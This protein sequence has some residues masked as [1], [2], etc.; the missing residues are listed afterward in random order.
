[1]N[2]HKRSFGLDVAR[3]LAISFVLI[4]HF[5]KKVEHFGFWGVELFF[6]LSG[7]LIGQILW[8]NFSISSNWG[9]QEILNFWS[10]RWWRTLPNYLLFCLVMLVFHFYMG[11]KLPGP[12]QFTKVLFFSQSLLRRYEQFFGV[13]WSLCIEE[14]FYLLFPA[15]L[16]LFGQLKLKRK[17]T[18]IITLATFF[19]G[20]IFIR[21]VLI[22]HHVGHQLRGITFA[23]LDAI[24][25]GVA[26]A[27]M[28]STVF[29]NY[30]TKLIAFILGFLLL[31]TAYIKVYFTG[32]SYEMAKESQ[33]L[34]IIIPLGFSLLLPLVNILP[35]PSGVFSFIRIMTERMSS[36]AYSIY[37]SHIPVLFL[38][39]Y[40]LDDIRTNVIGNLISKIIGLAITL[41]VSGL[42]YKYFELPFT[43]KRPAELRV[44][45]KPSHVN[46]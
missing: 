5:A 17:A 29:G 6:G 32:I 22:S 34:L 30:K 46:K 19:I 11:D 16:F 35:P 37:L 43:N 7:F 3:A 20:S 13:S 24:A 4:A 31:T 26:I 45:L 39:Y 27:F 40:L 25:Y 36:W 21:T 44:R 12:I 9:F 1:M 38:V 42:L 2:T 18:F 28:F 33:V 14:W 8:R 10:R 15:F 23:R 41:L